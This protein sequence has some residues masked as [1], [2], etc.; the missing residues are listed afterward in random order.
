VSD[1]RESMNGEE[2][3]AAHLLVAP[4][5]LLRSIAELAAEIVWEKLR[6][7]VRASALAKQKSEYLTA[8]EAMELL[9]CSRGRLDNLT[10]QGRLTRFH[11][12]S[13]LL[14]SRAE[15]E[16]HLRGIPQG[17]AADRVAHPLP[18]GSRSRMARGDAA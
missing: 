7:E 18:K 16:A 9:R 4:P 13:K 3:A 1:H 10:S 15:I 14:L 6:E 11:D 2:L 12:G 5:A 8:P 17:P